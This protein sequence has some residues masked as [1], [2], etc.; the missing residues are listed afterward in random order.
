MASQKQIQD[1]IHRAKNEIQDDVD[2][3]LVPW[4]VKTFSEL[5]D[6]VDANEYGGLTEDDAAFTPDEINQIQGA[7]NLW[8]EGGGVETDGSTH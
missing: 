2:S 4:T 6:H 8:L 5:H 1:A 3:G 7:V